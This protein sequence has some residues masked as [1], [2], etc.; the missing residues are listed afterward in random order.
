MPNMT[1]E[2][3]RQIVELLKSGKEFGARYLEQTWGLRYLGEDT[4]ERFSQQVDF[5]TDGQSEY[6]GAEVDAE[7]ETL[8]EAELLKLL[9]KKHRYERIVEGIS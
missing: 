3:A 7:S 4:F 5:Q 6:I 9:M 8:S 1:F 2:E